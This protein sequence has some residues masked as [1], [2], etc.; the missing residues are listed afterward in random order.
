MFPVMTGYIWV[1]DL[2]SEKD[3]DPTVFSG[4]VGR[5]YFLIGLH[6][7]PDKMS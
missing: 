2:L 5:S 3:S 1:H 7:F 6:I 4:E